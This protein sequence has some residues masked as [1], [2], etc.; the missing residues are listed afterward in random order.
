MSHSLFKRIKELITCS[1]FIKDGVFF[2]SFTENFNRNLYIFLLILSSVFFFL[3]QDAR[4]L[5]NFF[6]SHT[7]NWDSYVYYCGSNILIQGLDPYDHTILRECLPGSWNFFYNMPPSLL[8]VYY[9]PS[10]LSIE[11]YI[12]SIT[13]INITLLI[14]TLKEFFKKFKLSS[15]FNKFVFIILSLTIWDGSAFIAFYTGNVGFT[16]SLIYLYFLLNLNKSNQNKFLLFIFIST[17]IKPIYI[18]YLGTIFFF[19]KSISESIKKSLATLM[20][21]ILAYVVQFI[22]IKD[23]TIGF[24]ENLKNL[25][26]SS[27][28]GFGFLAT[29]ISIEEVLGIEITKRTNLIISIVLS[30]GTFS[31]CLFYFRRYFKELSNYSYLLVPV[32]IL[33]C[34]PRI[35]VYDAI[36][37]LPSICYI[38]I[39]IN[40]MIEKKKFDMKKSKIFTTKIIMFFC[41]IYN[42]FIYSSWEAVHF[43]VLP[44]IAILVIFQTKLNEEV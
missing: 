9:L 11:S 1:K 26:D 31:F 14:F 8:Y 15:S 33:I 43:F 34:F 17:L 7:L 42:V 10:K 13:L 44:I 12:L 3:F 41:I 4:N 19:N 16:I 35:K 25:S 28:M 38:P 37:A 20:L 6:Y 27:D 32:I 29:I 39:L 36:F 23:T 24:F 30:A 40:D 2:F 5:A 21:I 22:L 18:L